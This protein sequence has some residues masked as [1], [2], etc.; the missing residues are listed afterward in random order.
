MAKIKLLLAETREI[1]REGLVT[2]LE[3]SPYIELISVCC[4]FEE[5]L[6]DARNLSP[7]VIL[8]GTSIRR[9]DRFELMR[10]LKLL[11]P[12]I[13]V[14]LI[15]PSRQDYYFKPLTILHSGADGF[16]SG[17]IDAEQ[18]FEE[19]HKAFIGY[20]VISEELGEQ[21]LDKFR[22]SEEDKPKD[23]ERTLSKREQEVLTLLVMGLSNSQIA[24]RLIISQNTVKQHLTKTYRKLLVNNR[25]MAISKALEKGL[26]I[27]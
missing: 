10:R 4:T 14:I 20:P 15:V 2:V 9:D 25:R 16:L 12:N 6:T 3:R 5:T 24:A 19:I 13:R 18:L 8:V 17:A 26:L 21:L 1:Y 23:R 11:H 7:D 22:G 27:K